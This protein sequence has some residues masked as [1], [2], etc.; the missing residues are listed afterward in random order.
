[1]YVSDS[2]LG[3]YLAGIKDLETESNEPLR[4]AM[5]ET[6]VAQNL[7]GI[8]ETKWPEA[9]IFFWNIQGRHEV[10]FIITYAREIMAIEVGKTTF[11]KNRLKEVGDEEL[12]FNWD[13]PYIKREYVKNPHF[14][15]AYLAGTKNKYPL[16]AFD[17]IHKHKEWKNIL[18]GLYDIHFE[19]AQIIVTGSARLDYFR[20]SG[21]SLIGRYFSYILLPLGVAE[22]AQ[23][24]DFVLQMIEYW[25][26]RI[27]RISYTL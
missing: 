22:A 8:I 15:K 10:D 9:Q 23:N 17:E 11:V 13:D 4:G 24:F 14:L 21:D 6:Y 16:V 20:H 27:V 7:L 12:Y 5:I 1:V 2:G 19:E 3:C 18:K 25:P 26:S